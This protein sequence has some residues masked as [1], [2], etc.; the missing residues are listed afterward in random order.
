MA[1]VHLLTDLLPAREM[2]R[3]YAAADAYV[4]ASRGEGWGRPFMEALAMGLPT[5]SSRWGGH[6]EFVDEDTSWLV[7]G[8]LVDVPEDAELFNELYRGHRW[9]EPEV[10]DLA[11]KIRDVARDWNAARRRAAPARERLIE[12]FGA[13]AT[14][15][16]LREAATAAVARFGGATRPACVIRGSSARPPRSPTVNDGLAAGLEAGGRVVHHRAPG[17]TPASCPRPGS[18]TPGRTT[19][20]RSPTDPPS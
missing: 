7:E 19:S 14:A 1:P 18:R 3:L 11:A 8:N 2:P 16:T 15:E 10:E 12:R 4:L 5:I 9:F 6:R 13:Q 17:A 20:P